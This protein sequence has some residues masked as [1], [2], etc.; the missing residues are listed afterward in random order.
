MHT[1]FTYGGT[2]KSALTPRTVLGAYAATNTYDANTA[3]GLLPITPADAAA[4]LETKNINAVKAKIAELTSYESAVRSYYDTRVART[5][6]GKRD[7]LRAERKDLTYAA[8]DALSILKS[9]LLTLEREKTSEAIAKQDDFN[10]STGKPYTPEE[11]QLE[12]ETGKRPAS[13]KK[14]FDPSAM[15][16][17]IGAALAALYFLKGH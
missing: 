4:L 14:G 15:I 9:G 6:G 1:L 11:I 3:V 16:I 8:N 7:R 10:T 5:S 17:P 12:I 2:R 13:G